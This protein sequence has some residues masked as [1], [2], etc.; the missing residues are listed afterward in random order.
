MTYET[1]PHP[2]IP[3]AIDLKMWMGEDNY[4]V[5]E[6]HLENKTLGVSK[7]IPLTSVPEGILPGFSRI[8]IAHK[9][10]ILVVRA[11]G[12]TIWDLLTRMFEL[13][14]LEQV[15]GGDVEY[16]EDREYNPGE[17]LLPGDY[18][19]EGMLRM[20]IVLDLVEA[21]VRRELVK[22]FEI[23]FRPGIIG[24]GYITGLQYILRE[25]E[26]EVPAEIAHIDGVEAVRVEYE[27]PGF[28]LED[29][30]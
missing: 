12:K 26:T 2:I 14:I 27:D 30:D 1:M 23:E 3:D 25:G 5:A 15:E 20:V 13:E 10:A 9:K 29:L 6:A 8:F 18:V 7:R 21:K 16:H 28:I 19:P 22:E 11:E 4:S 17:E 24:Y